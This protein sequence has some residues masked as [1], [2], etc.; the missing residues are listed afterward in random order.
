M[1]VREH[2]VS[3]K[4]GVFPQPRKLK[5][6][7]SLDKPLPLDSGRSHRAVVTW[8]ESPDEIALIE[9]QNFASLKAL[10]KRLLRAYSKADVPQWHTSTGCFMIAR[11]DGRYHRARLLSSLTDS[12]HEVE[13]MDWGRIK[14]LDISDMLE[15]IER[16]FFRDP[17]LS[18]K[19]A[20]ANVKP[21]SSK[22]GWSRACKDNLRKLC[23]GKKAL[24]NIVTDGIRLFID[25]DYINEWLVAQKFAHWRDEK[26]Q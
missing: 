15:V 19:F 2:L 7:K 10:E 3:T 26:V 6:R 18:H 16:D 14:F 23:E 22:Y 13:M 9:S 17:P 11:V 8:V 24:I 21:W 4:C 25:D 20:L 5:H 1:S 12:L